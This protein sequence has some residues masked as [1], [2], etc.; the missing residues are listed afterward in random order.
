MLWKQSFNLDI[1][2]YNIN[3]FSQRLVNLLKKFSKEDKQY[4]FNS[5]STF[6]ISRNL[7]DDEDGDNDDFNKS[8][9]DE[10]YAKI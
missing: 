7:P 4:E 8:I 10:N 3:E 6:Y 5:R 1:K 9:D 2:N